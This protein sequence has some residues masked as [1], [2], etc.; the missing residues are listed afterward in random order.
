MKA[1]VQ[2]IKKPSPRPL[3]PVK[4]APPKPPPDPAAKKPPPPE[5]PPGTGK[6]KL[7]KAFVRDIIK[8][9]LIRITLV[10]G[11]TL[12]GRII[13]WDEYTFGLAPEDGSMPMLVHKQHL[14]TI[15]PLEQA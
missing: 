1:Q 13:F 14:L 7:E 15:Q 10:H 8:D 3:P 12:C 2:V 11:T 4:A 5:N 6:G 9:S